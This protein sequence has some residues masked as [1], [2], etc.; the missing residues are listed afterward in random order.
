MRREIADVLARHATDYELD[1]RLHA[2]PPH[3]VWDVRVD[4]RRAVCKTATHPEADPAAEAAVIDHVDR[5]TSVPVPSILA[6]GSNHFLAEW[7]DDAPSEDGVSIDESTVRALGK[8]MATLHEETAFSDYGFPAG[9]GGSLTIDVGDSWRAVLRTHLG[10]CRS[11]LEPVGYGPEATLVIDVLDD[12]STLRH[13]VSDPVLCHGNL[14]PAHVAVDGGDTACV[15]DFEHAL[16]APAAYDY[17]RTVMPMFGPGADHGVA[18]SVFREGYESV[19]PLPPGVDRHQRLYRVVN[20]VS[21]L[22]AL[23]LQNHGLGDAERPRADGMAEAIRD[24]VQEI[25]RLQ[26]S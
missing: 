1:E 12:L 10:D 22:V 25:R 6:V 3:E 17:W 24:G 18:E 15:I 2:V 26:D 8:T 13:G 16:V 5:E 19:S 21:Y 7:R 11:Y 4:G 9:S 20:L 14:L 23:D